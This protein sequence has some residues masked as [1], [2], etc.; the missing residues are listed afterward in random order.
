MENK[1]LTFYNRIIKRDLLNKN[2]YKKINQLPFIKKIILHLGCKKQDL[3]VLAKFNFVLES[4][5]GSKSTFTKSKKSNLHLK[6]RKGS[7]SGCLVR[8]NNKKKNFFL[9]YLI[10][11]VI[12]KTKNITI[13]LN[14]ND[15]KNSITFSIPSSELNCFEEIEFYSYL[16]KD[17]P[18]LTISILFNKTLSKEEKNISLSFL[19]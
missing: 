13:D 12:P 3:K 16:L 8:L 10:T 19:K 14:V 5:T 6:T 9:F 17:L 18:S 7:I 4:I 2:F 1:E 15:C 11:E